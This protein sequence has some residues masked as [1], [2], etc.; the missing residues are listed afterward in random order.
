MISMDPLEFFTLW[1]VSIG[2]YNDA[3]H[4]RGAF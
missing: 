1:R 4:V 3:G 2:V